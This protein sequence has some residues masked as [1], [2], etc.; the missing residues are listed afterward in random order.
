MTRRI[1]T[2]PGCETGF[3]RKTRPPSLM[4]RKLTELGQRAAC[5]RGMPRA[6]ALMGEPGG[7]RPAV[8]S[9]TQLDRGK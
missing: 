5:I 9:R 8:A 1:N 4:G 6:C 3:S 7:T 2:F